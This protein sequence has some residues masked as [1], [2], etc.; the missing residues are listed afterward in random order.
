V[1]R[2]VIGLRDG[3][4]VGRIDRGALVADLGAHRLDGATRARERLVRGGSTA[5]TASLRALR[6]L[7]RWVPSH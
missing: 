4:D 2:L 5:R 3:D 7:T 1:A 6:G